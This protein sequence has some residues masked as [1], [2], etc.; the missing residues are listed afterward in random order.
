MEITKHVL[1]LKYIS[2]KL[3]G[4]DTNT[5]VFFYNNYR[6]RNLKINIL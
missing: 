1:V 2:L 6:N 4:T 5:M 3:Y